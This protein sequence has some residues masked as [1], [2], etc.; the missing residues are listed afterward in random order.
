MAVIILSSSAV[1]SVYPH[2]CIKKAGVDLLV[3][4]CPSRSKYATST[5]GVLRYKTV[6]ILSM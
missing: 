5:E 1:H 2:M 3:L 6:V 4:C